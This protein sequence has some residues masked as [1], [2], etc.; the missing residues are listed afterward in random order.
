LSGHPWLF[1]KSIRYQSR[2][3]NSGDLAVIFDQD[4]TFV[5]IGIYDP[6]SPIR[7]RILRHLHPTPINQEFFKAQLEKAYSKRKKLKPQ[8]T[9]FR[10]VHGENDNF[11]GLV[12][13]QYHRTMVIKIYS[14]AWVPHLKYITMGLIEISGCENVI[15]R[16][17]GN[18]KNYPDSLFGLHKGSVLAGHYD[19]MTIIFRENDIWFEA[20]PIQ[21]HKTGF[22]F[23][24]RENRQ[25][26]RELA[27]GKSV[28]NLFSYTGGFSVYAAAGGAHHVTS[29]DISQPALDV[30]H[31]NFHRN[32]NQYPIEECHHQTIRGD[33]FQ[34]LDSLSAQGKHFDLIIIDPPSFAKN[35]SETAKAIRAYQSLTQRTFKILKSGGHLVQASC[36]SKVTPDEFYSAIF[37][38]ASECGRPLKEITKTRHPSDHP[39]RFKEGG[40]LKCIFASC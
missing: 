17:S 39:I 2:S 21:G 14:T 13:D 26:A 40:Y 3:G 31:R 27:Q 37:H 30:A 4:R 6:Y 22:Y 10:I 29:V 33:A 32:I 1:E 24:Q 19:E 38:I 36:S 12:I 9:G 15:L 16:T 18:T 34:I 25:R 5:A 35:R 23:D 28:L 20:D 11:P 7:V 8:T